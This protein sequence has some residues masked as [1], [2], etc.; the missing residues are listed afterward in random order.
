MPPAALRP[1]RAPV[2]LP[3]RDLGAAETTGFWAKDRASLR[4]CET[5][6]AAA[7]AATGQVE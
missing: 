7:A 2:S 1:C 4:E 3:D 6:R 5:R